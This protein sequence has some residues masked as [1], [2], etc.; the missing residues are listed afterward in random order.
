MQQYY[1]DAMALVRA[2]GFPDLFIT[3]TAN[4]KWPEIVRNLRPGEVAS[5]RPD[6]VAR[7]FKLKLDELLRD[8]TEVG[9]LG[10]CEAYTYVVEF[11]KRG[12]P[13]AHILLILA[14]SDKPRDL[15]TIDLLVSAEMPNK[16]TQPVLRG[17]VEAH[18]FHGPCGPVHT[19]APC[20]NDD[21]FCSK[22]YPKEFAEETT[23]VEDGYPEYRRP[24]N[25]ESFERNGVVFDN[26]RVV[27]YNPWLLKKYACHLNVQV[28]NSIRSI[29]YMYKYTYKGHDRANVQV[30]D[31]ATDEI[32][33]F[34]DA[35]Y[36]GPA[37]AAW[38][39][40]EFPM[41]GRS[42]AVQRLVV[43]KALVRQDLRML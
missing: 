30:R 13:H 43:H 15:A 8:V 42:H 4:P 22:G 26:T 38:R 10:R 2:H 33:E 37:E 35:R 18:M 34:L 32:R 24:Q 7:V 17:L 20:M 40:F 36:V 9:V 23:R 28:V 31:Q 29:K 6:L 12:L 3:M 11:Q 5:D 25:G 16:T 19:G 1:Q 14:E 39:L 41:H 27:P 21:G